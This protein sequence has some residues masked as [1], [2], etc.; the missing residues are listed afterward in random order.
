MY[1]EIKLVVAATTKAGHLTHELLVPGKHVE[2]LPGSC[3]NTL[4]LCNFRIRMLD[5]Y[6]VKRAEQLVVV[7][8]AAAAAAVCV[9]INT[10][11][12]AR[13]AKQTRYVSYIYAYANWRV[14]LQAG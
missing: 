3:W 7:A 11:D 9:N 14:R 8:V 1:A 6:S 10:H 2:T 13:G 5:R 12:F 4:L